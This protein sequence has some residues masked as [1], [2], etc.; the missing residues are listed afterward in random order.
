MN[1]KPTERVSLYRWIVLLTFMFIAL[2]SQLLWLTFAPISS[3]IAQLFNVTTFDVSL[4]SLVWPII[5]VILAI[6]VG[7]LLIKK[8]SP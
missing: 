8:A 7:I 1:E 3:E 6:P 5:F 4:L 2:L